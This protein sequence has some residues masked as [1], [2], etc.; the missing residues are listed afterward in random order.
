[1][2][3]YYFV[4]LYRKTK[5][6]KMMSKHPNIN[7]YTNKKW[8]QAFTCTL[9]DELGLNQFFS[10][11]HLY[12]KS[13][14]VINTVIYL[15]LKSLDSFGV[16]P[17]CGQISF[18]VHS[19]YVR[20]LADL[21]ILGQK[22]ILLFEARKFFCKNNECSRKTFAEQPGEEICRY[23]RRTQR[24]EN[25][26]GNLCAKMSAS[27]AS[28]SLQAMGIPTSKSTVLRTIYRMPIPYSGVVTELG[29]DDWAFRKGMTYGTILVNMQ[30][31]D[32]IDLLADRETAS[33]E[34]WIN[35]HPQITL[36]SRDRSTDYSS[37]IANTGR[38]I[39]EIAD[40]FHLVKNMTDCI[41]KVISE[42][43]VEYRKAISVQKITMTNEIQ[44][45]SD[46]PPATSVKI[47]T[48]TNMF[49]EVK[50]LQAKGFKINA[51]AK[52]LH[53]ARQTVRKYMFYKELPAR[54]SKARN[55]YYKFDQYV[56]DEYING[57]SLSQIYKDIKLNG[58]T[59]SI[60]PFHYHYSYL[61]KQKQNKPKRIKN[62]PVD[63]REPLVP[64]KT[65]SITVFK[66][67]KGYRLKEEAKKLIDTLMTFSW[68][69]NIYNAA[70]AFYEIIMGDDSSKLTGWINEYKD[71]TVNKLATFIKGI[72]LDE[73]AVKNAIEYTQSNGIVEG[74]VNKLK[75]IKRMMYGRAGLELLKRKM[76]LTNKSIQLK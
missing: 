50:E 34:H 68:F 52:Q 54:N 31:G 10:S 35:E 44:K 71:T 32:V 61:S 17:Y 9:G 29:V 19:T 12:V 2:L 63:G 1:M 70:K 65:I 73:K 18:V 59:G 42:N 51:I 37:A 14:Q 74:L 67:I 13:S 8:E 58:F 76:I 57:K 60:S 72:I 11:S 33:F 3:A 5:K 39:I 75:T 4:S 22:V 25:V 6:N 41:T 45:V 30:T 16:C 49:N 23:Q 43:Y 40:R 21:P 26:V 64:I 7:K 27:S 28:L 56:E 36:V 24:C 20:T 38:A 55:E 53:I 48:R 15:H 66:S 46:E 47:D 69:E 62:K